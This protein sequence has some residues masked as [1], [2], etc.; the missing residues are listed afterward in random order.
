MKA[1][2]FAFGALLAMAFGGQAFPQGYPNKP[3]RMLVGPGA[4]GPTDVMA[5]TYASKMTEIWGQQ[6]VVENRPGA[7]NTIAPTIAA[8]STPD[9]YTIVQCGISDAIAPA[10]Y[11][12]LAY[13]LLKD[14]APISVIGTT[15]NVLVVHPSVPARSVQE[16]IA[17]ARANAGKIDYGSTGVGIST[18]LSMELFKTM[19]GV[20]LVH[21]PYKA[22]ALALPDLL[23]GRITVMMSNLPAQVDT[24]RSGKVRGLGVTT[25][26][27]SPR[28]PEIPTIHESGVPGFEVMVWYGV[29][30]P[31]AVPAPI[32]E[33]IH[34]DT[35]KALGASDLRARLEQQGID[36]GSSPA[37]E[38]YAAFIKSETTKWTKVV[39]DAN[40]PSQ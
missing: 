40:I 22:F 1:R 13:D 5:R 27:R 25:L 2:W 17:H 29:C 6:V 15:A 34:A 20:N 18:H 7:G 26:K 14:F 36:P 4:G 38:Q 3:V 10:L 24:I 9:G 32:L 16:F 8:K 19:A 12:K 21:V 31:A 11:K 39:K 37:R 35:L 30:A 28:L 33:K 23:A